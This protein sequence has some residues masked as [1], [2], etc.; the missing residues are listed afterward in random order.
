MTQT[1]RMWL[2]GFIGFLIAMAAG[3]STLKTVANG[4]PEPWS[5]IVAW[6]IALGAGG[7]AIRQYLTT[8]TGR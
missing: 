5:I 2:E 3:I 6:V 7:N 8:P 1:Q 4:F